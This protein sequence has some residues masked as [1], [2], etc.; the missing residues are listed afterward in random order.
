[1]KYVTKDTILEGM[2]NLVGFF[3]GPDDQKCSLPVLLRF[4]VWV[5]EKLFLG[6]L[7]K[8]KIFFSQKRF[9]LF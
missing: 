8:I 7:T 9:K 2:I 6:V 4:V 1:M 5:C 3:W